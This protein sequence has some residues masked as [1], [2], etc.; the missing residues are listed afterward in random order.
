MGPT[1]FAWSVYK[2]F[3]SYKSGVYY[4]SNCTMY[5]TTNPNYLGEHAMIMIG[6]GTDAA[7]GAYWIARNSWGTNWGEKGYVRIARN[8]TNLCSIWNNIIY[9]LI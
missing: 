1:A 3:K 8:N 9:P 5:D 6:Y 2:S 4:Q 7:L